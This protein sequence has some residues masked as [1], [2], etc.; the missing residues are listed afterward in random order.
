MTSGAPTRW[1]FVRWPIVSAVT[2]TILEP[3]G[4]AGVRDRRAID[5]ALTRPVRRSPY[6]ASPDAAE[7][8]AA[9]LAAARVFGLARNH[10]FVDG[11]E[12]VAWIVARLFLAANGRHLVVEPKDAIRIVQQVAAGRITEPALAAWFRETIRHEAPPGDFG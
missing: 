5:S 11:I 3:G 9:D 8:E 1:R 10:G 2:R 6:E 4:I 7:P 12:R